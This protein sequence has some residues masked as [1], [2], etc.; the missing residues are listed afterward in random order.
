M[1]F[2]QLRFRYKP[3]DA[4]EISKHVGRCCGELL[5]SINYYAR[6]QAILDHCRNVEKVNICD[7]VAGRRYLTR[8]QYVAQKPKWCDEDAWRF[9]ADKWSNPEWVQ[10]SETNRANR[11]TPRYKPYRGGSNSIATVCQKLVSS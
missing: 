10:K 7:K 11:Y 9:F 1:I 8:E 6:I 4:E 2:L 3:E 5:S